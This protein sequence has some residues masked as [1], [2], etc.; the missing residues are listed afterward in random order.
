MAKWTIDPAN[1][2][3]GFTGK[4]EYGDKYGDIRYEVHQDVDAILAEVKRDREL[5]QGPGKKQMGWRKAFTIPDVVAI[6]ILE[7][8][9]L[10]VHDPAFFKDRD[11]M[12]KLKR[13]IQ[14]DYPYLLI[15]T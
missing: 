1:S 2:H 13:V 4:V 7:K 8:Y 9:D 15:S 5:L 14:T 6:E 11:K 3:Q 12:N 10:D